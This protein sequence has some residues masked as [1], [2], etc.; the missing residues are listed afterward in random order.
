MP[1]FNSIS[2]SGYHMQKP[3]TQTLELALALADGKDTCAPPS[4]RMDVDDLRDGCRSS[5]ASA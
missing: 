5:S 1:R 2:I 3:A 4:R